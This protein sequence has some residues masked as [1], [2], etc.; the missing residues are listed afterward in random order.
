MKKYINMAFIYAIFAMLGGI[1]YRE[2]TKFNNFTG[3]TTLSIIHLHLFVLGTILFLI[4]ALFS[5]HTDLDSKKSFKWFLRLYN[6]GLSFMVIMFLVKGILQTLSYNFTRS[7]TY[8]ISGL[9]GI[10][11]I[12]I[13][14]SIILLFISLRNSKQLNK[15][16]DSND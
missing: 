1:F 11:H 10:S 15:K 12:I 14:I 13:G 6:I 8:S 3:T 5:M 16:L 2:F 9:S 7:L 4:I